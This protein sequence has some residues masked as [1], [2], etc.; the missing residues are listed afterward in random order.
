M[1]PSTAVPVVFTTSITAGQA[2]PGDPVRAKTIEAVFLPNGRVLP[3]GTSLTGHVVASTPFTF[4]PTPYAVQ[5]PSVL[6]VRLDTI[7]GAGAAL[8]VTLGLRALAGPVAS[9]EAEI[10]HTLDEIDGSNTRVLIGGDTTS[11]LE[12]TVLSPN[13]PTVGYNH[14][15][16]SFARLLAADSVN[17]GSNLRC[18][19]TTT[20]QSI[21]IFSPHACGVYGLHAVS[22]AGNGNNTDGGNGDGVFVLESRQQPVKLYAGTTALLEV[23]AR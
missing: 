3:S 20:E 1:P 18:D 19:A 6:S 4:N 14:K 12:T 9:H 2:K 13:G 23:I 8:P 5:Q 16:G 21:G 7:A 10:P 17:S 22:L 11:P 15:Q